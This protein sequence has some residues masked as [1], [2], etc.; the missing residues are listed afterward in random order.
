MGF[1]IEKV[2]SG[3][4]IEI[5]KSLPMRIRESS[6]LYENIINDII[7]KDDGIYTVTVGTNK[8]QTIYQQLYK[9]IKKKKITCLKIHKIANKIYVEKD[10]SINKK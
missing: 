2:R 6:G 7:D 10:T 1:N 5:A 4:T 8:P 3:Y 9:K